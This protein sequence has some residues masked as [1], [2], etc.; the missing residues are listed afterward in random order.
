MVDL[1]LVPRS[2]LRILALLTT[3]A[4]LRSGGTEVGLVRQA[5]AEMLPLICHKL[6]PQCQDSRATGKA[7]GHRFRHVEPDATQ[8]IGEA[9]KCGR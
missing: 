6:V 2:L 4:V 8:S 3:S 7:P 1:G 9:E 5:L